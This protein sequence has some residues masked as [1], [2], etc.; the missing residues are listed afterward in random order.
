[1]RKALLPTVLVLLLAASAALAS[2]PG[3][4]W[5]QDN[6]ESYGV[7]TRLR[8]CTTNWQDGFDGSGPEN[9]IQN[10]T[11]D[12]DLPY[13]YDGTQYVRLK[14]RSG[15]GA[16]SRAQTK[17][18]WAALAAGN[19]QVMHFMLRRGN[20]G[21]ANPFD[22]AGIWMIDSD[23]NCI[24][25][26]VGGTH[27]MTPKLTIGTGTEGVE[28][29]WNGAD[30]WAYHDFDCEYYPDTGQVKF[31]IDGVLI[32][33]TTTTPGMAVN[34]VYVRDLSHTE[35]DDWLLL[36]DLAV[37][38]T[39]RPVVTYPIGGTLIADTTPTVT[40]TPAQPSGATGFQVR[41]CSVDD[42]NAAVVYDSGPQVGAETSWTTTALPAKQQL[43]VFVNEQYG[44]SWSGFSVVGNG[45]FTIN[46]EPPN[47]PTITSPSGTVVGA[48]PCIYWTDDVHDLIQAKITTTADGSGEPVWDSDIVS[49]TINAA[50]CDKLLTPGV[51]YYALARVGNDAGWS[52]WS[53]GSAFQ[54][55]RDGEGTDIRHFDETWDVGGVKQNILEHNAPAPDDGF[56]VEL[57]PMDW[58]ALET[59]L[60]SQCSGGNTYWDI[61]DYSSVIKSETMRLHKVADLSLDKGVTFVTALRIL[62][63]YGDYTARNQLQKSNIYIADD[64]GA[65]K[66][67]VAFRTFYEQAGVCTDSLTWTTASLTGSN[68]W[69]VIRIT[70]RNMVPGDPSSTVWNLYI[71]EDPNPV[72][73]GK[74]SVDR[75]LVDSPEWI[76]DGIAIGQGCYGLE[77]NYQYDW[78]AVNTDG[79]YK[80]GEW[81]PLSGTYDTVSAARAGGEAKI[82][83]ITGEAVITVIETDYDGQQTGFWVQDVNTADHA[84]ILIRSTDT[85]NVAVGHKVTGISGTFGRLDGPIN[86]FRG[87][88]HY[89]PVLTNATFMA[90][91]QTADVKPLAMN[92]K[93]LVAGGCVDESGSGAENTGM[94]V[95]ITGRVT[96]CFPGP[97]NCFVVFLDDGS[98]LIDGRPEGQYGDPPATGVRFLL[99]N[100]P[101]GTGIDLDYFLQVDGIA[102]YE[103]WVEEP[104]GSDP[105]VKTVRTILAPR[106]TV[107]D[108]P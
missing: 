64:Y 107:I 22:H 16:M 30:D 101:W 18:N 7:G 19:M 85:T 45:G 11:D 78:T 23:N 25:G 89:G 40:W 46:D 55:T 43:W 82:C 49:S 3:T 94:F 65:G 100:N 51:Q 73:T 69:R 84:G 52:D 58:L 44:D 99:M 1:M 57:L 103:T 12:A 20:P 15:T 6:F 29:Q 74:G 77:A 62:E 2:A 71:N 32:W 31:Y 26:W 79:D 14:G 75:S 102:A 80:P 63:E 54:V 5:F 104:A 72:V 97:D 4:I 47:K 37:G 41:V 91:T 108:P 48:K 39:P 86:E 83:T 38:T 106:Y 56:A 92:Q 95:R 17:Y 66:C 13:A 60:S 90:T 27:R 53:D 98:G 28:Y 59:S 33:D 42:P 10:A 34:K 88:L 61:M 76:T 50:S 9:L 35:G 68:D 87:R 105:E 67:M 8:Q 36:D 93:A 81:V 96:Q 21:Y 24:A 70:G